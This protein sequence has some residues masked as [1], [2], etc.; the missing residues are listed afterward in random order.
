MTTKCVYAGSFCPPT[1]GH[2]RVVEEAA[3]IFEMVTVLCSENPNKKELPFTPE[4]CAELWKA[5]RLP[6]NVCV[7]T[8][9]G[10]LKESADFGGVVLI[11]GI[12][13]SDDFEDEKSVM[14]LNSKRFGINKY[15]YVMT[16][17]EFAGVSSSK[18]R[19]LAEELQ[20]EMLHQYVAPLV[21]SRLLE[22][23]LSIKNIVLVVGRPGS[24]KSTLL[25]ILAEKS[26]T[27][28]YI[29]TDDFHDALRPFLLKA[30]GSADIVKIAIENREALAAVI[31]PAWM[32]MLK[33]ALRKA[34]KGGNLFIEAAMGLQPDKLLFRF[35]GGKVLYVGC[36]N[37]KE[38]EKR[39]TARGNPQVIPFITQIPD[40][41]ESKKVAEQYE[42]CLG[43]V[44]TGCGKDGMETAAM[45]FDAAMGRGEIFG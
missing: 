9:R 37:N 5:Y 29:N 43:I 27:N 39:I 38:L 15:F 35:V 25:K 3:K 4:E 31:A 42:L 10:V 1:Y 21:I 12:R 36:E 44:D 13:N 8:L 28:A 34:P 33:D 32:E 19:K 45:N 30:F 14:Q 17:A 16:G 6:K 22:K 24:G 20:I 7:K 11:R 18:V 23:T 2:L 26:K 41:D 40:K